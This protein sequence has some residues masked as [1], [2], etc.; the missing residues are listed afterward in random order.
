MDTGTSLPLDARPASPNEAVA[1]AAMQFATAYVSA[2]K[3]PLSEIPALITASFNAIAT[4]P[5][6]TL[7]AP[8]EAPQASRKT[9]DQIAESQT[10]TGLISFIDGKTYKVL[11]RHLNKHGMTAE[12][13]R[14]RYGLP[15]DYPMV[16]P[17]YSAER[18]QLARN[19][20]LGQT[21][22]SKTSPKADSA[23]GSQ[24]ATAAGSE[25]PNPATAQ[26]SPAESPSRATGGTTF[27]TADMSPVPGA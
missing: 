9:A 26:E 7:A 27:N 16:T 6:I 8:V 4:L 25:S 23:D 11:T 13:Y 18:A 12:Q 19:S 21:R 1:V 24:T 2:N 20:G 3:L 22:P 5:G 14:E 10:P 15:L 17:A